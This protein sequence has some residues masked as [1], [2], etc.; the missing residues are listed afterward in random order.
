MDHFDPLNGKTY[1]QKYIV[2]D[3][4]YVPGGPIFCTRP[5]SQTVSTN[6]PAPA[7]ECSRTP[8]TSRAARSVPGR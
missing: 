3:D 7:R 6:N 4:N 2:T 1:Q 8:H 5:T